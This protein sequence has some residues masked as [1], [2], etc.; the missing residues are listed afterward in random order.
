M[1]ISCVMGTVYATPSTATVL[2]NIKSR[3]SQPPNHKLGTVRDLQD[4]GA[5]PPPPS[6]LVPDT[7]IA[8]NNTWGKIRTCLKHS[9]T[10]FPERHVG[11][12]A[13]WSPYGESWTRTAMFI[14]LLWGKP[15]PLPTPNS[16]RRCETKAARVPTSK[17]TGSFRNK[18]L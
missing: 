4:P 2:L 13:P 5:Q 6:H 15:H 7:C 18:D 14:S 9:H 11:L 1:G 17:P 3:R 12:S 8:H 16:R 10:G